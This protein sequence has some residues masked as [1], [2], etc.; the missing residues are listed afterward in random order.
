MSSTC[1]FRPKYRDNCLVRIPLEDSRLPSVLL[2]NVCHLQNKLD[3]LSVLSKQYYPEIICITESWL[4]CNIPNIAVN[5]DGYHLIRKD[6]S[7]GPGGG[8]AVYISNN[9][10]CCELSIENVDNFEVLWSIVRPKQLPRPLSCLIIAVVYC[11][12]NYDAST[13]KKLSSFIISS[14]DRLLRDY[15]DAGILL[16]GDFN[17]LQTNHFNKYL[18]LSQIVKDATRK[19]N[20]LD[21]I[22]TNCS[23]FYASPTILSPVGKSDHN[24]V[25]VKPKCYYAYTK[26][27]SRVVT[28]QNLSEQVLD[29]LAH[30]INS[31]PWQVMYS[32]NDCRKQADF[33]Y[34]RINTAVEQT[35]PVCTVKISSS[36]RPWITPYFKTLVAKRGR[37]FARGDLTLYRCLRNRVNRVRKSLKTQYFLDKVQKLK[38]GNPS[39]W[40]KNMKSICRFG[41]QPSDSGR[42]N[43]ILY[44][45]IPVDSSNLASTINMHLCEVTKHPDTCSIAIG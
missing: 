37:A 15:P 41:H 22:F 13:M 32:M 3:D 21:K 31:I 23:N 4:S 33:F 5:L 8:V 18:N 38:N 29:N 16:T 19:N 45:S 43:N 27:E 39:Q 12:P 1:S 20:I 36:D 35:V 34:D 26:V 25:L 42:F 40:W 11:P 44:H 14:C 6:R 17:S 28:K 7:S 30:A 24:C 9:I 2:T 10:T